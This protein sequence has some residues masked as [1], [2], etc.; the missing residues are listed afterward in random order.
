VKKILRNIL[1]IKKKNDNSSRSIKLRAFLSKI[2]KNI[3]S[4]EVM[5]AKFF[6]DKYRG[7]LDKKRKNKVSKLIKLT[8]T[9]EKAKTIQEK[10]LVFLDFATILND[11]QSLRDSSL[12][13]FKEYQ[14]IP[15]NEFKLGRGHFCF[16]IGP[17]IVEKVFKDDD[18]FGSYYEGFIK[19][20]KT[21]E[22][23]NESFQPK[24]GIYVGSFKPFHMGHKNILKKAEQI[25]DK[26][27]V[28]SAYK[29]GKEEHEPWNIP[30]YLETNI[31]GE[32]RV[33]TDLIKEVTDNNIGVGSFSIIRGIR[34]NHDLIEEQ[35]Y[36]QVLKDLGCTLPV[37]HILADNKYS[38]ISSSLIREFID[39][40]RHEEADFYMKDY[41]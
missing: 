23:I 18:I 17:K 21:L 28:V 36:S 14:K 39:L 38:H 8:E 27:I 6:E 41:K 24:I 16:S 4:N 31:S 13:I 29:E 1:K 2:G 10:V 26:V 40:D 35:N 32:K 22:I 34:N 37:V 33:I 30:Y 25:F 11:T 9:P 20:F 12:K 15:F 5:S 3:L 7:S 19:G